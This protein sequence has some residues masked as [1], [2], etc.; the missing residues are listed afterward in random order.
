ML[1][2]LHLMWLPAKSAAILRMRM[3]CA[4]SPTACPTRSTNALAGSCVVEVVVGAVVAAEDPE[5]VVDS[6]SLSA[7]SLSVG[8]PS[9]QDRLPVAADLRWSSLCDWWWCPRI[10]HH[11]VQESTVPPSTLV[12]AF[13]CTT[14]FHAIG[15][16]DQV[17]VSRTVA[18]KPDTF[19]PSR[20]YF[21]DKSSTRSFGFG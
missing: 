19:D 17:V 18:P 11:L 20:F 15:C 6:G 2:Q 13:Q 10:P 8:F 5:S 14:S 9:H 7:S 21:V 3:D 16:A 12:S 4:S 1:R